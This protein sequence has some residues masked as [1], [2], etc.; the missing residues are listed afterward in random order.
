LLLAAASAVAIETSR[1]AAEQLIPAM[2][3]LAV[4]VQ[5]LARNIEPLAT[6]WL[7]LS[8]DLDLGRTDKNPG[9]FDRF[10]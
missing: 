3:A 1:P 5:E 6:A 7:Q 2:D 9:V 4:R 10:K 8:R